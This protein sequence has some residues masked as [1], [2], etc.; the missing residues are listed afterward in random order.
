MKKSK[1]FCFRCNNRAVYLEEGHAP[2]HECKQ[3]ESSV[4]GCYCFKPVK[5]VI[6]QLRDNDPRPPF[7]P[8]M[9]AGRT[10]CVGV[11][12]DVKISVEKVDE[13]KFVQVW[14][15]NKEEVWE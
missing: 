13:D 1:G 7:L 5:P 8:S 2:R 4:Q 11:Y 14:G 10:D 6:Q 12:E 15:I 3:I 9:I